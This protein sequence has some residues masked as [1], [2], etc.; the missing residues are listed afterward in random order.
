MSLTTDLEVGRTPQTR[1][2]ANPVPVRRTPLLGRSFGVLTEPTDSFCALTQP[3]G[4][5]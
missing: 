1:Y 3:G 4:L 2:R 5:R